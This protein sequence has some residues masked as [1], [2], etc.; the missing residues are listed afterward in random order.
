MYYGDGSQLTG[1]AAGY[2]QS[3]N[4]GDDVTFGVITASS[5]VGL[6]PGLKVFK[7]ICGEGASNPTAI[8]DRAFT[9][10]EGGVGWQIGTCA[11]LNSG[12]A[13]GTEI[14]TSSQDLLLV[15]PK[16]VPPFMVILHR[17]K[18]KG[19]AAGQGITEYDIA[20]KA[21]I[22]NTAIRID[23]FPEEEYEFWLQVVFL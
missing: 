11:T 22:A 14:G 7:S 18:N 3:C 20:W 13:Y 8:D 23:V 2:D 5:F 12:G 4:I 16:G 1:I 21:N 10:P 9:L 15:H 6:P 17:N 19:F